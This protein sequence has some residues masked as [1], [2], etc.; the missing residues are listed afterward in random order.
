[1]LLVTPVDV[2]LCTTATALIARAVS[3]GSSSRDRG[4][5]DAVPPVAGNESTCS[6]SF[7]AMSRHSM[8][9]WPVS[10]ISTRVAGR[11]RV[12]ER[13]FPRAGA[14]ARI[15]DDG[16]AGLKDAL[17]ALDRLTAERGE[18]GSAMIDGRLRDG[19]QHAVRHVGRTRNLE[20]VSTAFHANEL[21][22]NGCKAV[23]SDLP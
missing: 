19:A 8:A 16:A 17:Q 21:I 1:M 10:T 23:T 2:S 11:E 6:P 3:V 14:R 7:T 15:H 5:V 13:R 4:G 20:E 9:N 18:R 12:D 22:T